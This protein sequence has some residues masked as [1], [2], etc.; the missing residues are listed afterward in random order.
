MKAVGLLALLTVCQAVHNFVD[1]S[2][3]YQES[4][5]VLHTYPVL[6]GEYDVFVDRDGSC[7]VDFLRDQDEDPYYSRHPDIE[8]VM[9]LRRDYC[10]E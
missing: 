8:I 3:E 2:R 9:R 7:K 10:T 1:N 4:I 5:E 6:G